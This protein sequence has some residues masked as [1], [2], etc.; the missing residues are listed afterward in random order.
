MY[1]AKV[2]TDEVVKWVQD[3]F[4]DK[5]KDS[6]AVI[7][8]SGGKDS[9]VAAGVLCKA[10]G[11]D[12]VIG[13]SMPNGTQPDMEDVDKVFNTL[14]I[15]KV[16]INIMDS[17][18]S[19]VAQL[20]F[21]DIALSVQGKENLPPRLRMASLY[22]VAQAQPTAAFVV[23][24]CNASEDYVGY[25]TKWGDNVGDFSPFMEL[26]KTEVCAI[27]KEL[28]L[29][30]DLVNKTPSDGLC[31]MSDEDRFGFTYDYLDNLI[32][33]GKTEIDEKIMLM[34]NRNLHKDLLSVIPHFHIEDT[35]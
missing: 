19:L 13:V 18:N 17:F 31:G 30:E 28:G 5:P 34:H 11:K 27:G 21:N 8:I 20:M 33:T 32:R 25:A 12:R 10:L 3:W 24:T 29:P 9:T 35:F 14:G 7:G 15:Q 22:L 6:K 16:K 26:T 23:N 2:L 1:D 4:S